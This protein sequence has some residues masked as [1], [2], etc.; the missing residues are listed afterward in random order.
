MLELANPVLA[1]L[2]NR[3]ALAQKSMPL[4]EEVGF[5]SLEA[6]AA[7][8]FGFGLFL[9]PRSAP[10]GLALPIFLWLFARNR[11]AVVA[12]VL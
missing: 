3:L 9:A 2:L 10:R 12:P 4:V 8:R 5:L 11:I 1:A 6:S 7:T